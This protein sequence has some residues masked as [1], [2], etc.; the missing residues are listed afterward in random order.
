MSRIT[1]LLMRG[2]AAV[3]FFLLATTAPQHVRAADGAKVILVLDASGSMWGQIDG[4]TKIEM[5][6]E[7]VATILSTWRASDELGLIAY[8]HRSKGDCNDIEVLM[9]PGSLDRD[10]FQATVNKLNPK[11]KTPM[12]EAVRQA[13]T[14]LRST[15]QAATVILVSDG[16]ETCNA[17]PCAVA[18]ELEAAGVG[19]TVHAVGLDIAD[20]KTRAQLQCIAE[21]TG[22]MFVSADNAEELET[23]LQ[24]TVAAAQQAT[25]EPAQ[26]KQE[27]PQP[28]SPVT[29]EAMAVMVEGG[30]AITEG[31]AWDVFAAGADGAAAGDPIEYSYDSPYRAELAP[32]AYVLR[33]SHGLVTA[34][35]PVEIEA[36]KTAEE[37]LVLNAGIAK[38]RAFAAEGASDPL[39]AAFTLRNGD[40]SID[41][42]EYG[43]EVSFIAAAGPWQ[44]T[45]NHGAATTSVPVEVT[46]GETTELDIV[47]GTG[48]IHA[49]ATYSGAG[50]AV[51][52]GLF[53][54]LVP[55]SKPDGE[56]V[57][58][59]YD[60]RAVLVVPAGDYLLR[61]TAGLAKVSTPVTVA[62]GGEASVTAVLSAGVIAVTRGEE[63][64]SCEI[65]G[66]KKD[67]AGNRANFG[68]WYD[69]QFQTVA[70]AGD[71]AVVC[72][73][74]DGTKEEAPATVTAGERTETAM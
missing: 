20:P 35:T 29:L 21:N 32:G 42:T 40:G 11:G 58:Y 33:V 63:F 1:A 2:L 6:R 37:T 30:A 26:P 67:I 27:A 49:S 59:S 72:A 24:T 12:T 60:P 74:D 39:D 17:D 65:L 38:V 56:P 47:I 57:V 31:L 73:R 25:A 70:P 8:G 15:E 3:C 7:A 10:G 53:F 18:S 22:G 44:L 61:A 52:D 16:E 43:T 9:A 5:A 55:A 54:E 64:S 23:A 69:Q 46:A 4:R 14:A 28:V 19:L 71:Y 41:A 48:T 13:A 62:A 36:G 50:D 34:E 66:A 45:V 68:Y 51:A